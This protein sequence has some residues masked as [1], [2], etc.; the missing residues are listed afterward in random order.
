[1]NHKSLSHHRPERIF[2][3]YT[4][5]YIDQWVN[6]K[7]LRK[8]PSLDNDLYN[9]SLTS[10]IIVNHS[11][12]LTTS[13]LNKVFQRN[14]LLP[15]YRKPPN[16]LNH[17]TMKTQNLI[18]KQSN[19]SS[20]RSPGSTSSTLHLSLTPLHKHMLSSKAFNDFKSLPQA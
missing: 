8:F 4:L 14:S 20:H 7:L 6:P 15:A 12:L 11:N 17:F 16:T 2:Q 1:M 18:N 10:L 9:Q 3:S 19:A 5:I 13:F